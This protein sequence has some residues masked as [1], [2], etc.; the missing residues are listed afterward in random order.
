MGIELKVAARSRLY[1]GERTSTTS[2]WHALLP[3]WTLFLLPTSH[4]QCAGCHE[5]HPYLMA[6][7]HHRH[8]PYILKFYSKSWGAPKHYTQQRWGLSGFTAFVHQNL[9]DLPKIKQSPWQSRTKCKWTKWQTT[10]LLLL[11]LVFML[12]SNIWQ[13]EKPLSSTCHK[14][15]RL[16]LHLLASAHTLARENEPYAKLSFISNLERS[17]TRVTLPHT[18]SH[19]S[20]WIPLLIQIWVGIWT[21]QATAFSYSV[22]DNTFLNDILFS[23]DTAIYAT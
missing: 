10:F 21:F 6:S 18:S 23:S 3:T 17:W 20:L 1:L 8:I 13:S 4:Q 9:T 2:T 19:M 11:F 5:H 14:G 12:M 16:A 22:F 7:S 15:E